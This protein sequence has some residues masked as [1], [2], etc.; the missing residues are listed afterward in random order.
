MVRISDLDEYLRA[1]VVEEGDVI[2]IT[3]KARYVGVE[4]SAFGRAYLEIP[5]KLSSGKTKI[6]T[7]NKTTLKRL[8][9][10]FGD[11]TDTWDGKQVRITIAKQNVRG[12]MRDVLY[13]EPVQELTQAQVETNF[14]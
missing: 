6:W 7:P 5:V 3:G 2:M 9:R 4:E 10:V 12:E 8:A 14:Q 1:S 11:D 13:G